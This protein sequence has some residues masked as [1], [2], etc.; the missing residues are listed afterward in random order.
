MTA[1]SRLMTG[2]ENGLR[3]TVLTF[4]IAIVALVA[5][6]VINRFWLHISIIWVSDLAIICFIWLG[7]LT[8]AL[9]VRRHG[10]FRMRLM[11]DLLGETRAR[12]GLELFAVAVALAV[13][14][15]LLFTGFE[16]TWRGRRE[17]SPGLGL[18]MSWAY[19]AL[20]VSAAAAVLFYIEIILKELS[21]KAAEERAQ[22][23][24]D[25]LDAGGP[26]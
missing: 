19:L 2:V 23:D 9:A 21:G 3:W 26:G 1:F 15:L 14:G 7:F 13:F 20:P 5:F 10:H 24:I 18:T 25:A 22:A 12:Q 8:A 6:Q 17:A 16:M 11:L 4:Y